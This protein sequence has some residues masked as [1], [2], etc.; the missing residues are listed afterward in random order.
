M[1]KFHSDVVPAQVLQAD[2]PGVSDSA[3]WHCHDW[4]QCAA[5]KGNAIGG[6]SVI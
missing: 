2:V 6:K 3:G 4:A 1:K 5:A